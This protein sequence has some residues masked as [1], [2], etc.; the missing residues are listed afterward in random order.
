[1]I[2]AKIISSWFGGPVSRILNDNNIYISEFRKRVSPEQFVKLLVLETQASTTLTTAK[3]VLEQVF[4]TGKDPA[5]I[6]DEQGL[7]QINDTGQIEEAVSQVIA[8]NA[9]AVADFR[10]GK[11]TA[12]KFLV[13]QVMRLTG[14]RANPQMVNELLKKKLGEE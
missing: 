14:G 7:T 10:S 2:P 4:N 3:Y 6:I 12:L 11:E 8:A 5:D 9:Q 1:E 13:G